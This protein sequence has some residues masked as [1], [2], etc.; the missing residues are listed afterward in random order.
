LRR[1][2]DAKDQTDDASSRFPVQEMLDIFHV[3]GFAV[4]LQTKSL[5]PPDPQFVLAKAVLRSGD[6]LGL[7][8]QDIAQVIGVSPA[9]IS[10]MKSGAMPL[11]GK[12]FELAAHLVRVFRSLDAIV[13]GD[14][15]AMRGWMR[16]DNLALGGVPAQMV[17]QVGGLIDVVNYL[18]ARRAPI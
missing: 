16:A 7:S 3:K 15:A 13:G 12:P 9:S 5:A 10:R 2:L 8:Q 4:Q 18:D 17:L 11:T 1:G 6:L 14:E